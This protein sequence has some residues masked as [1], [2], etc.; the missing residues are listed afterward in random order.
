[1]RVKSMQAAV[2]GEA[3][4]HGAGLPR[5]TNLT[6]TP[7][8]S[9]HCILGLITLCAPAAHSSN[10]SQA[11]AATKHP[12]QQQ[13]QQQQQ[14]TWKLTLPRPRSA[15][16]LV[17]RLTWLGDSVMPANRTGSKEM[18]EV[19]I[20]ALGRQAHW[21][22]GKH[23]RDSLFGSEAGRCAFSRA[24]DAPSRTHR[25]PCNQPGICHTHTPVTEL[26]GNLA[27]R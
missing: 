24:A 22:G 2:A 7:Y 5:N 12:L 18:G 13:Q 15:A 6:V 19:K 26:S 11:A 10:S 3:G 17:P 4:A 21:A 23:R 16:R 25:L 1:V 8:Q 27:A 20:E 9:F 14:P